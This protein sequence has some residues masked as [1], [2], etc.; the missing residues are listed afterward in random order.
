MVSGGAPAIKRATLQQGLPLRPERDAAGQFWTFTMSN[1][2]ASTFA[3]TMNLGVELRMHVILTRIASGDACHRRHI[4]HTRIRSR[5]ARVKRWRKPVFSELFRAIWSL[6][7]VG[8]G[9][10]PPPVSPVVSNPV[11]VASAAI[12][13]RHRSHAW[14]TIRSTGNPVGRWRR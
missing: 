8:G 4:A 5:M 2:K 14:R 11:R 7:P 9:F 3:E 6:L 13:N 12:G 1:S 10:G